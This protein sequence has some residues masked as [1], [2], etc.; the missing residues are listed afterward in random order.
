M[1][2]LGIDPGTSLDESHC[3]TLKDNEIVYTLPWDQVWM[4]QSIGMATWDA[5]VIEWIDTSAGIYMRHGKPAP[6]SR[7]GKVL[8]THS[9]GTTIRDMFYNAGVAVYCVPR[10]VLCKQAGAAHNDAG[11]T[12]LLKQ[13]GYLDGHVTKDGRFRVT[14]PGLTTTHNRDALVAALFNHGHPD[15]Q[16]W[17]YQP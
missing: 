2:T 9:V 10:W 16:Q 15:N 12:A 1:I 14:T 4:Q 3:A 6:R 7:A 8:D 17:R 11:V 13:R 5:V